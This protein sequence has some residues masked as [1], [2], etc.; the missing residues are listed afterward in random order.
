MLRFYH[1][2]AQG[3]ANAFAGRVA[4]TLIDVARYHVQID[5]GDLDALKRI[6]AKLPSLPADL[7]EKNK[8]LLRALESDDI[9]ARLLFLPQRL[10]AEVAAKLGGPTLPFVA[11]QVAVALDIALVAPL[12]PQNL[13]RLNWRRHFA[14]PNGSRGKLLL[15]IPAAETKTRKQELVFELPNDV[16]RRLR[17]YRKEILPRLGADPN[18]D[19]FVTRGGQP[20]SQA[21][22]SQQITETIGE[23]VGIH[24]TPH[25]FRHLAA[26][27]YLEDHPEDFETVRALLGHAWSKTTLVYAGSSSRRAGKAFAGFVAAQRDKLKLKAGARRRSRPGR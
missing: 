6:A 14:E 5:K 2:Q 21:T 26:V 8:A 16:A 17:W 13:C 12:R 18:G 11:A 10:L 9:R 22:L 7:T 24:M 19:L 23:K 27:L 25:Q 1:E 4:V 15:H 20:K 3:K